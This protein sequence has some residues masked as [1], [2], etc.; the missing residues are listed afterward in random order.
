MERSL[1]WYFIP[2]GIELF[3]TTATF[4]GIDFEIRRGLNDG[5]S[6]VGLRI[7][8]LSGLV[9]TYK[10]RLNS[11]SVPGEGPAVAV[12]V[13]A[14][15]V[16][17]GQHVH[18][19]IGFIAS[20]AEQ[21]TVVPY[22]GLRAMQVLPL[23]ESAVSDSP[24]AGGF[25]GARFGRRDFGVSVEIGVYYDESALELR[26]RNVIVVPSITLHGDELMRLLTS[27]GRR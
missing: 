2:D 21:G 9:G 25:L 13:G 10:R 24:T 17:L 5:V 26:S 23:S 3:D 12:L 7:P 27:R 14:G 22:G 8:M 1:V 16:N 11:V 19:E 18:G 6:D 4:T 20:A 15:I